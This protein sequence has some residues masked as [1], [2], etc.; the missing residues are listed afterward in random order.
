MFEKEMTAMD[1]MKS[2]MAQ[3]R[4]PSLPTMFF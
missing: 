2:E 1:R 4:K 3:K